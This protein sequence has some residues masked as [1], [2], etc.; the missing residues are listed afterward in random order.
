TRGL[1]VV[2]CLLFPVVIAVTATVWSPVVGLWDALTEGALAGISCAAIAHRSRIELKKF[3]LSLVVTLVGLLGMEVGTRV[4]LPPAPTFPIGDG[5]HFLLSDMILFAGPD[6]PLFLNGE[7]PPR[8]EE[9]TM[10]TDRNGKGH[11][12]RPPGPMVTKEVVCSIAYGPTYR[13]A[14]DVTEDRDLVWPRQPVIRE[15][16][17]FRVLHVGDSMVF[18]ANEPR[19]NAFPAV[20]DRMEPDV[21]HV[22][23]GISGMAPDD[24]FVVMNRWLDRE[25][26]DLVVF[27]VFSGNDIRAIGAP[28]PCSN[29][30]SILAYD[31]DVAR[32]RYPDG[33]KAYGGVG[34]QWLA[35]N[36]P[37]PYLLRV[38]IAEGSSSAAYLGALQPLRRLRFGENRDQKVERLELIL[39]TARDRL[40]ARSTP[41]VVVMLP[42][43]DAFT[44]PLGGPAQE[45]STSLVDIAER[46]QIPRLDATELI[47]ASLDRGEHPIQSDR[48][49]FN[50]EG[51]VLVAEWLYQRLPERVPSLDRG[52]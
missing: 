16:A 4:L 51:H 45:L 21:Q 35:V 9:V 18:G 30:D 42:S 46:L 25:P 10:A 14:I 20:L 5:P 36:S 50:E 29:W 27:Y 8:L 44:D 26:F 37:L 47:R 7:M 15:D 17:A 2:G 34:V 31:G 32:L 43:S 48:T 49:H 38:L 1:G 33:P 13:G 19:E 23:A 12:D 24:Y 39:R 28:H 3:G 40:M 6:D 11:A 41:L 52:E 22:N